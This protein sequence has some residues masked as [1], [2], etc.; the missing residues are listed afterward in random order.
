MSS[1]KYGAHAPLNFQFIYLLR[2]I[3]NF[4]HF[5]WS[6]FVIDIIINISIDTIFWWSLFFIHLTIMYT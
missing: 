1:M 2:S 5:R 6:T 3:N 4:M